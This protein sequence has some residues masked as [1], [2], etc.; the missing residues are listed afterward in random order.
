MKT[1]LNSL[2]R[3]YNY[4]ILAENF[5]LEDSKEKAIKFY[6]KALKFPGDEDDTID[7]L[8][9][10]AFIYDEMDNVKEA[11]KAYKEI[12]KADNK[13]AGAYYGMATL[14]ER[15]GDKENALENYFK[16]AEIR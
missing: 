11:L 10:I 16:A 1:N 4:I 15:L 12:T 7:I 14:Y 2:D 8:Y 6:Q 9:N 13:E 5:Y 3:R